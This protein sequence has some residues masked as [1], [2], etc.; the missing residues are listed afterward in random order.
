MSNNTQLILALAAIVILGCLVVIIP[1]TVM[2]WNE[3]QMKEPDQNVMA[4]RGWLI[5]VST[6]L[7][8]L[9][10]S[11]FSLAGYMAWQKRKLAKLKKTADSHSNKAVRGVASEIYMDL[12]GQGAPAT[13]TKPQ[14]AQEYSNIPNIEELL[15]GS[16]GP[17]TPY[18]SMPSTT[19]YNQYG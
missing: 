6:I 7:F 19:K 12:S 3:T 1:I 10:A 5:T 11:L 2:K 17:V 18:G 16:K 4:M 8:L 13:K 9:M 14:V 15:R